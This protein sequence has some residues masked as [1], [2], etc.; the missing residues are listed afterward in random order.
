MKLPTRKEALL[1]L[2]ES[3]CSKSVVNHTKTVAKLAVE[4]AEQLQRKGVKVDLELVEIGA[5]LHDIGRAKTH[6]VHHAVNG[7]E[8]AE[9]LGLPERVVAVIERHVGG[10]ITEEEA[11]ELGWKPKSYLP[12]SLEEKIVCYADKLVE[13]VKRTPVEVTVRKLAKKLGADHPSVERVRRLHEEFAFM[14]G[15]AYDTGD[16]T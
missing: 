14:L 2:E 5:L 1:L 7:A 10:G 13:G 3:G 15:D 8:I 16:A 4:I 12:E 11:K 6:S 9:S